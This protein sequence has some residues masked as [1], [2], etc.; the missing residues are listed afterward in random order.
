M[1]LTCTAKLATKTVSAAASYLT[2]WERFAQTKNLLQMMTISLFAPN[3]PGWP[4]PC[5]RFLTHWPVY[6]RPSPWRVAKQNM[7]CSLEMCLLGRESAMKFWTKSRITT[8]CTGKL[9]S[10]HR[11]KQTAWPIRMACFDLPISWAI[12]GFRWDG[13]DEVEKEMSS[14]KKRHFKP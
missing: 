3:L 10:L 6:I 9:L 11:T 8:Y 2:S 14:C 1:P 4:V 13:M 5:M 7:P 12:H